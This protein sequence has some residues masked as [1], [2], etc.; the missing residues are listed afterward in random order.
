MRTE[1]ALNFLSD[2]NKDLVNSL[3][4]FVKNSSKSKNN[5]RN[6]KIFISSENADNF[7]D[8]NRP[9][10]LDMLQAKI[11]K[12]TY[13]EFYNNP[14]NHYI[15]E[16]SVSGDNLQVILRKEEEKEKVKEFLGNIS[17]KYKLTVNFKDAEKYKEHAADIWGKKKFRIFDGI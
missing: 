14:C 13:Q 1:Q 12:T 3:D 9:P 2:I 5:F 7:K 17:K 4:D 11:T 16:L 8:D 6:Y 10:V 15:A